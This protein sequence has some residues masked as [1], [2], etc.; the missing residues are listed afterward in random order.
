MAAR[1]GGAGPASPWQCIRCSARLR[2]N[3]GGNVMGR[4]VMGREAEAEAEFAGTSGAVRVLLES[5]EVILRGAV[6]L[7]F[8]RAAITGYRADGVDLW[9]QT[10]RG[11]LRLTLGEAEAARW[12]TALAKTPPSLAD[13]LGLRADRL[14]HLL[15]PLTDAAL[16]AATT[17]FLSLPE[18]AA[19][20]LAELP[21]AAS[22]AALQPQ[23]ALWPALPFWGVTLKGKSSPFPENALRGLM[24]RAGYIDAKSC[25]VSSR[26]SATRY[27]PQ[28]QPAATRVL[29]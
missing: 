8:S 16:I 23:L 17:P 6:R 29:S 1:H 22:L 9:L 7:R 20:L 12:V 18:S 19:C 2:Q 10:D 5:D 21:D 24:R 11:P 14:V 25:A 28:D 4:E 15:A 27:H 13:K 3:A 26:W